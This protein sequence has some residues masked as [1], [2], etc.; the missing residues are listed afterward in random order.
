MTPVS[1]P[2]NMFLFNYFIKIIYFQIIEPQTFPAADL[3]RC[4]VNDRERKFVKRA[5]E[6]LLF[7]HRIS[8]LILLLGVGMSWNLVG[9]HNFYLT[10]TLYLPVPIFFDWYPV[11]VGTHIEYPAVLNF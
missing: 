5:K 9:T 4:V 7:Y 6:E 8:M 3:I 2:E 1:V 10:V 11:P